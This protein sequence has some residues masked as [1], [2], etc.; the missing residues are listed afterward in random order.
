V[1][2]SFQSA[3]LGVGSYSG[4]FTVNADAAGSQTVSVALTVTTPPPPAPTKLVASCPANVTVASSDGSAMAVNYP[5]P[6]ASGGVA[7]LNVSSSPASGSMFPVGSTT[8]QAS[9]T[10]SDGQ[11]AS[12]SFSVAVTYTAPLPPPPPPPAP[13]AVGPQSTITCPAG[14]VDIWPG[15][16]I[17]TIVNTYPGY[18]TFC[19][20]AGINYLTSSITPKTGDVFVGEYGSILD[21]SRWTT[22]DDTQA[23]FRAHNQD[24]DYVTVRNMVIRNMPQRGIHAYYYMSD[25]WT[26]EYNEIASSKNLGIVF[27]GDSIVR[28]NYIHDNTYGGYMADYS[29]RATLEANEIANNGTQQKVSESDGVTFR[30]NYV[31]N[32]VGA[33]IWFDSDNTNTLI[34]GNRLED[35]GSNSIWFEIGSGATIRNNTIR[36]SGDTAIFISTSKNADVY[37]NTLD[38]NFRGITYFLNCPSVGGGLISFDLANNSSHDN[39]ITVGTQTYPLASAF[40]FSNCSTTQVA[41]YLNGQ[42]N[43]TFTN[44]SYKVPSTNGQYWYWSDFKYWSQW[45]GLPQD[46]SGTVQ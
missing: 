14:A 37:G 20:R 43:L 1:T 32:N 42:K 24:I 27:P 33:G 19:F 8:V 23:A 31:H 39:S 44:N 2:V 45:Q 38:S 26:V 5:A 12:C 34:E 4:S 11:T 6:T 41:P 35:N 15:A 10:S 18:T 36:R 16:G 9:A 7:P 25:H 46:A 3:T 30:N 40:N 22:S 28:N 21:G 17:Q 13:T 29:H